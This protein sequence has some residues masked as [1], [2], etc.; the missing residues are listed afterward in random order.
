[1]KI[2]QEDSIKIYLRVK[3]PKILNNAYYD[4]NYNKNI[5]L[6]HNDKNKNNKDSFEIKFDK[7]FNDEHKNS[8]IYNQ[9]CSEIIKDCLNGISFCFISHGETV[10]D[11]L[12]T[13]IGDT[14]N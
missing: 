7:I 8:F 10:S 14:I 11:K 13:L 6:L 5:F 3:T 1:M 4:I 12:I 9:T 2:N